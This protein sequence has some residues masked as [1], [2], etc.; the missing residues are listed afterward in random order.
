MFCAAVRAALRASNKTSTPA[1]CV[2]SLK[3]RVLRFGFLE[4]GDVKT[5]DL[6]A[7]VMQ[8][9]DGDREAEYLLALVYEH[10]HLLRRDFASA[11]IWMSKS[12]EQ[13]YVPAQLGMGRRT[14]VP[15]QTQLGL[16]WRDGRAHA[17]RASPELPD[18]RQRSDAS[19]VSV[20][21]DVSQLGDSLC[22]SS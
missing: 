11:Q 14:V 2:R 19:Y 12:A 7:L 10:G 1:A 18:H 6:N 8:V 21:S 9:Q 16:P 20:E 3:L 17:A 13:G 5:N 15:E 4:D 22:T